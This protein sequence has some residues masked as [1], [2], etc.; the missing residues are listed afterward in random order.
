MLLDVNKGT[1]FESLSACISS[2]T[3][4]EDR[5]VNIV[6]FSVWKAAIDVLFQCERCSTLPHASLANSVAEHQWEMSCIHFM[7]KK[8]L[9][10]GVAR[11]RF[12]PG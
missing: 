6:M 5:G 1:W 10:F 3:I 8:G 9:D 7:R 12:L 4:N 11:F 2:I